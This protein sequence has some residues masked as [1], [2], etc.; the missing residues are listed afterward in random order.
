[1]IRETFIG[2]LVLGF[3]FHWEDLV[4]YTAGV[5]LALSADLILHKNLLFKTKQ[6]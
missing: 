6:S 5:L 1:S 4:C 3:G 2:G